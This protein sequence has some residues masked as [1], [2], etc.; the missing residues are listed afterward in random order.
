ME[1]VQAT[2]E[3]VL[4]IYPQL[5]Q[6]DSVALSYGKAVF[7][8]DLIPLDGCAIAMHE[9]GRCIGAYGVIEM[10][11]GVARAWSLFSE[12]LIEEHPRLLGL[13]AHKDLRKADGLGLRRIEATTDVNS[14]ESW[15][16]LEWLGFER[17]AL[18]RK[19]G[20][21]GEDM[22]LYARVRDEL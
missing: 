18:M 16:F 8:E 17:E 4:S 21:S 11:P 15:K 9:G 5:S 3:D 10:W 6:R 7:A 12:V 13:H 1:F 19:Y 22:Y 20:P 2:K 14:E